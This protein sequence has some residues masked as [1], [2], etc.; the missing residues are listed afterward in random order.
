MTFVFIALLSVPVLLF[1]T[2]LQ[3][4]FNQKKKK[5]TVPVNVENMKCLNAIT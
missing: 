2:P 3:F 5:N 1:G 4:R